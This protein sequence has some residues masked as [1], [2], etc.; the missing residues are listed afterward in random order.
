VSD[1]SLKSPIQK[2]FRNIIFSLLSRRLMKKQEFEIYGYKIDWNK[3]IV[4]NKN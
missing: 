1:V 4:E 2:W 3:K